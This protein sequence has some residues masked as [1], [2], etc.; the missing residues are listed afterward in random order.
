MRE[1][2]C[3][4]AEALAK[5]GQTGPTGQTRQTCRT[6]PIENADAALPRVHDLPLIFDCNTLAVALLEKG[7]ALNVPHWGARAKPQFAALP[8]CAVRHLVLN[9]THACN[10]KCRYCFVEDRDATTAMSVATA[11][12]AIDRLFAPNADINISFFGG[13][14]L[15]A[16]DTVAA[17]MEHAQFLATARRVKTHFH[18]TTNGTLLDH[19]KIEVFRRRG[20][21]V[22]VSLDGPAKIHDAWRPAKAKGLNSYKAT[23]AAL[24]LL[25][26]AGLSPRVTIR[27]TYPTSD[28]RLLER[29]KYFADLQDKG[30]INGFSVEPANMTEGCAT[31]KS[32]ESDRS[33][34]SDEYHAAAQW[35]VERAKSGKPTGFF[36]F[37]KLLK[38]LLTR[39]I[40]ATECGAGCGYV[41]VGPD[42][43]IFACHREKGTR[44][45]HINSGIDEELRCA[46]R[47]NR[48]YKHPDCGNCWI[49]HVC[50]GGCR[51]VLA[52]QGRPLTEVH[53]PRCEMMRTLVTECLWIM[54][55][56]ETETLRAIV[57]AK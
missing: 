27:A 20:C 49:R 56:V 19:A 18:I 44:I 40:T 53:P 15:L 1:L 2:N 38:R 31:D 55:Q 5:A 28:A 57:G 3:L 12:A 41:T 4:P 22:L 30:Y 43:S 21:S 25:H 32:D 11:C 54:S 16:W 23:F 35:F 14:P 13:E 48:I 52:E 6:Y 50:G 37:V 8:D 33:D 45:G 9:V 17:V 26:E 42:G 24:L 51:Q 36:H 39:Q 47:D 46:W 7:E 29:L 10:L 34:L